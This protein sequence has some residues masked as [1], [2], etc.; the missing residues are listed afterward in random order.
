MSEAKYPIRNVVT[1][2]R[3]SV[4]LREYKDYMDVIESATGKPMFE[5]LSSVPGVAYGHDGDIQQTLIP[6]ERVHEANSGRS[7]LA[8]LRSDDDPVYEQARQMAVRGA[9]RQVAKDRSGSAV[10]FDSLMSGVTFG[11]SSKVANMFAGEGA[12]EARELGI[13]E[14]T[15]AHFLGRAGSLIVLG[16]LPIPGLGALTVGA[17]KGLRAG[18]IFEAGGKAASVARKAFGEEGRFLTEV[19]RRIA[20]PVAFGVVADAPLAAAMVAADIVDH[21]KELAAD[22]FASEFFTQYAFS[23]GIAAATSVPFAFLG[24]AIGKVG[25]R[26]V[27]KGDSLFAQRDVVDSIGR[28]LIRH[29]MRPLRS[30][31]G[32]VFDIGESFFYKAW[33]KIT[34]KGH[35]GQVPSETRIG[36]WMAGPSAD[37][38]VNLRMTN[39]EAV[40]GIHSAVTAGQLRKNIDILRR[41]IQSP[42][43]DASLAFMRNHADE[44]ITTRRKAQSMIVDS[45]KLAEKFLAQEYKHPIGAAFEGDVAKLIDKGLTLAGLKALPKGAGQYP[46]R[47]AKALNMRKGLP[48]GGAER[49]A[50]DGQLAKA[51]PG[52]EKHLSWIDEAERAS[53][54]VIE[55]SDILGPSGRGLGFFDEITLL[56]GKGFRAQ[57]R[58]IDGSVRGLSDDAAKII[59]RD[60]FLKGERPPYVMKDKGFYST[61]DTE[62][63]DLAD[64]IEAMVRSNRTVAS[65]MDDATPFISA[66][67]PL[68][69][70]EILAAQVESVM[71]SRQRVGEVLSYIARKGGGLRHT[72]AFGGVYLFR[73]MGSVE[74][75][76][77]AFRMLHDSISENAGNMEATAARV[78]DLV[79]A[80]ATFDMDLG[81]A[82]AST[83]LTALAYL[84][85]QMPRSD[86]PMIGP[87]DISTTEMDNF[88]EAVGALMA[89]LSAL[90]AAVDGSTTEMSVDAI[91]TV[92]PKLYTEIAI[93]VAEFVQE[94]GDRLGHDQLLGLDTFTGYALGYTDG[95]APELT[96]QPPYAQTTGQAMAIGGPENRRMTFQQNATASQKL[97]AL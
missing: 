48:V 74:E 45:R 60:V 78:G 40:Q 53:R 72:V 38:W 86:D 20:G 64:G 88:F 68:T 58:A 3:L 66:S 81:M 62:L 12:E 19:G 14:H 76:R 65:L 55:M 22:T 56:D 7:N 70:K 31:G 71:S 90:A 97:G 25:S 80:A 50:L 30:S 85:Q 5:A 2:S 84:N 39:K 9:K 24:A 92:Y 34:K 73:E 63:D 37:D 6:K 51:S 44:L 21:D 89:P 42:D 29:K 75:K 91:R 57:M 1:N 4:T 69:D 95:P 13:Q 61:I 35:P 87:E 27:G 28:G 94:H 36:R 79:D 41:N 52:I 77:A 23:I 8:I 54:R 16:L 83:H 67:R 32:G 93:D 96:M 33:G 46:E 59:D 10:A 17:S 15:G 47:L 82:M 49:K 18:S 43:L 26:A 11:A